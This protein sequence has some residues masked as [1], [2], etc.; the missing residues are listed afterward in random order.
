MAV[1]GGC[2]PQSRDLYPHND[3]DDDYHEPATTITQTVKLRCQPYFVDCHV[4]EIMPHRTSSFF[5]YSILRWSVAASTMHR[6]SSRIA[7]FLQADARPMFCWPRSASTARS[8]VW[9]GLPNGRFQSGGSPRITAATAFFH[10]F[11]I[12]FDSC[13]QPTGNSFTPN[14]WYCVIRHGYV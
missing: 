3:D 2:D 8:Q 12:P 7:A 5:F 11:R 1:A 14:Q 10:D 6:Q 13:A 9:L 4:M